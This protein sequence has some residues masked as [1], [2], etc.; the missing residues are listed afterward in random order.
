VQRA[1][2]GPEAGARHG[3]V[4]GNGGGA[5]HPGLRV[6]RGPPDRISVGPW[7]PLVIR[8]LGCGQSPAHPARERPY[9]AARRAVRKG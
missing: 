3:P 2:R 4:A 6:K 5:A 8:R 1:D 7:P 9:A